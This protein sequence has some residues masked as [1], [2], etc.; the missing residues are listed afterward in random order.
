MILYFNFL[1]INVECNKLLP[2]K[3]QKERIDKKK[4][5]ARREKCMSNC[6]VFDTMTQ[7]LFGIKRKNLLDKRFTSCTT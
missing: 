5:N 7:K 6:A 1:C 2:K 4:I 3:I